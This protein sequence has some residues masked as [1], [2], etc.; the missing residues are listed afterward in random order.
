MRHKHSAGAAG[1]VAQFLIDLFLWRSEH[2]WPQGGSKVQPQVSTWSRERERA[3]NRRGFTPELWTS[4]KLLGGA[5]SPRWAG[6]EFAV[7][8]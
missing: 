3:T 7:M 6:K 8:F 4:C 2:N 1:C 5:S